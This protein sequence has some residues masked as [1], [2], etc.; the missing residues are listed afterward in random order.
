VVDRLL[1][2]Y[3]QLGVSLSPWLDDCLFTTVSYDMDAIKASLSGQKAANP[4]DLSFL[5]TQ[6][7]QFPEDARKYLIWATF[8][9]ET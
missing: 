3:E 2:G 5:I 8:F 1:L 9:G 6:M 4:S 7:R